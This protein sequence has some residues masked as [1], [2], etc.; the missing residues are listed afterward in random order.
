MS[1]TQKFLASDNAFQS[2]VKTPKDLGG[3]KF[4]ITQAGPSFHYMGATMAKA[5]G[6]VVFRRGGIC[7]NLLRSETDGQKIVS[8]ITGTKTDES[9]ENVA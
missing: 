9:L 2:G 3:K 5:E 7:A 1:K 6:I 8:Y 4:A